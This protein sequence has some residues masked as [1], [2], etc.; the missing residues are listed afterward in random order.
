MS[1]SAF[2]FARYL[3]KL[4]AIGK[5]ADYLGGVILILFGLKMIFL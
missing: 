5:Y 2:F 3:K 1:L 4:K